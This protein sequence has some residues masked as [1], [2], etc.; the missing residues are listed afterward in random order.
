VTAT[1]SRRWLVRPRGVTKGEIG[2]QPERVRVLIVDD[3]PAICR[4]LKL[5]LERAGYD[6]VAAQS[7]D[8]ALTVL[9][10]EP[11][12]VLLLDLRIP[13]TRGDVVF[14]L[15]AATHPHLRHQTL[16]MTGDISERSSKLIQS[17]NCPMIKKP[18]ELAEM[19][20]QIGA[21]APRRA[22]EREGKSA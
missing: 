12:D 6:A 1:V 22:R 19:I 2:M 7:G 16:F 5:A 9:S 21:L 4:A 20:A 11:V 3:E 17:C 8:S 13:D 10:L 15:A 18:F 14:E